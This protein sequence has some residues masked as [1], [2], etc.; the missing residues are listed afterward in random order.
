MRGRPTKGDAAHSAL[1]FDRFTSAGAVGD[2]LSMHVAAGFAG[3]EP[4]VVVERGREAGLVSVTHRVGHLSDRPPL[5]AE[6]LERVP[7]PAVKAVLE[8]RD[9]KPALERPFQFR[10]A[11]PGGTCD[12]AYAQRRA[13]IGGHHPAGL[14]ELTN[15]PFRGSLL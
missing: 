4:E 14:L 5:A 2:A 12:V 15:L 6:Q 9:A 13:H 8:N 3:K 1:Q 10:L 11:H 7:H